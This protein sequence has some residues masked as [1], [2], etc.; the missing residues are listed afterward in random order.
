MIDVKEYLREG[1]MNIQ[2]IIDYHKSQVL[3]QN[4]KITENQ[5]NT[6]AVSR[7]IFKSATDL[8]EF[9]AEVVEFFRPTKEDSMDEIAQTQDCIP[10]T[11]V[12]CGGSIDVDDSCPF[13][14]DGY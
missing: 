6:E 11:W 13:C 14:G 4:A 9:H 8:R 7:M 12:C 1:E 2:K 3:I 10:N 5:S